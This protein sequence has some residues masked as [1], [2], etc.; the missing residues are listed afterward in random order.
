M[1]EKKRRVFTCGQG[2]EKDA[3]YT[4]N[5]KVSDAVEMTPRQNTLSGQGAKLQRSGVGDAGGRGEWRTDWSR[6]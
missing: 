3:P 5:R 4:W 2:E 6:V 1:Q